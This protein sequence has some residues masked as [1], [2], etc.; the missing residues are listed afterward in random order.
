[1]TAKS[2]YHAGYVKVDKRFTQ[3]LQF[4]GSYTFSRYMSNTDES[5][6]GGAITTGSPQIPQDYSNIDAEWSLSAFD[7]RHRGVVSWIYAL[8]RYQ[9]RWLGG[10]AGGRAGGALRVL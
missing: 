7:R 2:E 4:G 3:H 8:P 9:R 5:L 6:G 1:T 10:P